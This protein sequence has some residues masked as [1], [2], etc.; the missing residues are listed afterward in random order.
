MEIKY[1][2]SLLFSKLGYVAKILVW[3]FLCVLVTAAIGSAAVFPLINSYLKYADVSNAY[4][5]LNVNVE[6]FIHGATSPYEFATGLSAGIKTLYGAVT[7][8]SAMFVGLVFCII[9]IYALYN[10][11]KGFSYYPLA[12]VIN[13]SMSSNYR[14]GLASSMVANAKMACKFS[15]SKLLI[16]FPIDLLIFG[17]LLGFA[18]VF[19][20]LIPFFGLAIV[21]LVGI[22]LCALRAVLFSGWL[23]RLLFK[24]DEKIYT[25]FTRSLPSVKANL[26]GMF[27][28]YTCIFFF[29]YAFVAGLALPTFGL[30]CFAVPS[31]YLYMVRSVELVGYYK[32]NGLCFY[33]DQA[34]VINTVEYGYRQDNQEN[35]NESDINY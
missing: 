22:V 27:K 10:F 20:K 14:F 12:D 24:P 33:T 26:K 19:T 2:T 28:A 29:A 31:A 6:N 15:L 25:S 4:D 5:A 3:I 34:T 9:F 1:A 18:L 8:Q 35:E 7:N 16:S 13:K 32:M 21:L 30:I 11:L 17:I 23:P